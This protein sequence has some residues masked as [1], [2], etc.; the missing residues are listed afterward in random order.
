MNTASS[1]VRGAKPGDAAPTGFERLLNKWML[2]LGG[3]FVV[4][5]A[6]QSRRP[7]PPIFSAP[8]T[9]VLGSLSRYSRILK[10]PGHVGHD[11]APPPPRLC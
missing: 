6:P 11:P 9:N 8:R 1:S 3:V 5:A 10:T 4:L 7:P 2:C